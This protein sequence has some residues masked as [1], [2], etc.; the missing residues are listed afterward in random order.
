MKPVFTLFIKPDISLYSLFLKAT[1]FR[2]NK[3]IISIILDIITSRTLSI[4]LN[5]KAINAICASKCDGC[6]VSCFHTLTHRSIVC[7]ERARWRHIALAHYYLYAIAL[8]FNKID[9]VLIP[10]V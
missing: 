9:R 4:L 8:R 6:V 3:D 2:I 1:E 10:K 7:C 5:L